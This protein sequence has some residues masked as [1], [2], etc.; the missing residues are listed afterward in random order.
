MGQTIVVVDAFTDRPFAGN[1]AAVCV[2]SAPR[3]ERWM[4]AVA[5][6]MNLSETAFLHPELTDPGSYRLR[7][8]TPNTEVDLCGHATLASAHAL[9]SERH[10]PPDTRA[11][12]HTRSGP[13]TAELSDGWITLDFPATPILP[14]TA[15]PST[16]APLLDPSKMASVLAEVVRAPVRFA[17]FSKFDG[18]VELESEQ[19]VRSTSPDIPALASMWFRGLIV[20]A[21]AETSNF[22]FV[23]RF[24]APR[25][26][27]DEDPV[28]GS[29]HCCLGPYWGER[30]GKTDL[31]A[32]QAS[33]RGGVLRVGLRG[34]RVHLSGRAVTTVRGELVGAAG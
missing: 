5:R 15:T 23:S 32:Y 21:R 19:A 24:F 17:G 26:G 18:F 4:Q 10:L 9:W 7:W 22:D 34:P 25:V 6:E 8:F 28:C 1:P 2:M 12:F 27:I 13:L 31:H 30:L 3:E 16:P 29:A 33:P 14:V 11:R 20:T